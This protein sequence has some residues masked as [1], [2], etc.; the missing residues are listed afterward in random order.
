MP[1]NCA[2]MTK[3]GNR[4]DRPALAGEP[5][6]PMQSPNATDVRR[7]ATRR[8]GK[9]RSNQA[10]AHKQLP[11]AL[12]PDERN[13]WRS[14]AFKRV[15]TGKLVPKVGAALAARVRTMTTIREATELEQR[16][17]ELEAH[18]SLTDYRWSAIRAEAEVI[19]RRWVAAS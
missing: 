5:F 15:L 7:E 10:R 8:G 4:F 11:A 19:R 6:C 3:A 9:V 2:G 16:L 18:A 17:A 12:T 1:V 13:A 14:V